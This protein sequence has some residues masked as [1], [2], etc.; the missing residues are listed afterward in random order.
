MMK[1]DLRFCFYRFS[2]TSM[3]QVNILSMET[4]TTLSC[5]LFTINQIRLLFL[6]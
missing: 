3:L 2:S 4:S 6:W 5:T 1:L